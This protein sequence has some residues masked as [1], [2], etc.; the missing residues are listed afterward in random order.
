[1]ATDVDVEGISAATGNLVDTEALD[2]AVPLKGTSDEEVAMDQFVLVANLDVA[3]SFVVGF[4]A[5]SFAVD[6]FAAD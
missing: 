6:S 3:Y 2:V 1:M 4:E 5:G